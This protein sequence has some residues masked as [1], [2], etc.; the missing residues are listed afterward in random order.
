MKD[1]ATP[2][3]IA[4][5]HLLITHVPTI[6]EILALFLLLL[7][8]ARK[9]EHLRKVSFEVFF[10]IAL[11]TI[12]VYQS[13]VAAAEQFKNQ[14]ALAMAIGLH[15]DAALNAFV[16]I[17]LTGFLSWLAL[18]QIRRIGRATSGLT[19]AVMLFAV[20]NLAVV[21]LAANLGGDIHHPE[22]LQ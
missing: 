9:S 5:V 1:I 6:G 2:G 20:L 13:G 16:L 19:G 11:A 4:H 22:I 7:S 18:W 21:A 8:F 3:D 10:L 17:E 14:P 15:Q 12:P